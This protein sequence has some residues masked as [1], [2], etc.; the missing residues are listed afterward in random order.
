MILLIQEN[1]AD[2]YLRQALE[3]EEGRFR[4]Q[5]VDRVSTALARIAGGGVDLVILD[6]SLSG[7]PEIARLDS[8]LELRSKAP[9]VAIIMIVDFDDDILV[10]RAAKV[11]SADY[12]TRARCTTDLSLMVRSALGRRLVKLEPRPH[13]VLESRKAGAVITFMGAKGGVGT[14]SVALNVASALAKWGK[15]I[16]TELRPMFG[17][18]SPYF[19][20]RHLSASSAPPL[21]LD[22]DRIGLAEV[23]AL[24]WP[25]RN[26]PGL[27][28]FFGPQT[29]KQCVEVEA[30]RAKAIL[31][32]LSML[33]DYV[34]VD[35][36]V[37]FSEANRAVME[38]SDC[39]LLVVE[40]EPLCTESAKPIL[41]TIHAWNAMPPLIGSVIVNRAP[42][43]APMDLSDIE[44]QLAIPTLGVIPPA[45]D[46]CVAAQKAGMPLA[47]F[48]PDS[49]AAQ[50]MIS[51]AEAI[52]ARS[53]KPARA[54]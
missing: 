23:R 19:H 20:L 41:E 36:P 31:K 27:N 7:K 40:R 54:S 29:S 26:I 33:A 53:R 6:L 24:L 48:D 28:I 16:L 14:T 42:L 15:V 44:M 34:V 37:S 8:F 49:I 46:L 51:V 5:T 47:L 45:A 43:A 9:E 3:H 38:D 35:L 4:V 39:L 52:A 1:S 11:G 12:L 18:L 17:T 2:E 32:A 10:E 30:Q 22:A 21:E 50:G 25:H 13:L